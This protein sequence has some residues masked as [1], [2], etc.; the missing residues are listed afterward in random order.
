ML[1]H[2]FL[3]LIYIGLLLPFAAFAQNNTVATG[4]DLSLSACVQYALQH[5]PAL[6]QSY[7]DQSI[8]KSNIDISL[9]AWLPQAGVNANLQHYFDLPVA[10]SGATTPATV[11]KSGLN[12]ISTPQLNVSQTIFNPDVLYA[13]KSARSYS[14]Q[15][16]QNITNTKINLVVAVSK[17][18]YDLLLSQQQLGILEE[19]IARLEKNLKDAYSQY[20]GGT[21]DKVDYKRA[22]IALNNSKAELKATQEIL[23]V[24]YASLRQLIGYPEEQK[25]KVRFDTAQ[26]MQ[27]VFY[28]TAQTLRYDKR[29]EYQSLQTAMNLQQQTSKYYRTGFLPSLS[30]FYTYNLLYESNTFSDLFSQSYPNSLIGLNFSIPLFQGLKRVDN[31][32]KSK[33]QQERL[34]WDMANLKLQISTDYTL[35]LASYKSN[36]NELHTLQENVQI[37]REVYN[38]VKLQYNEGIKQYIE[39]IAAETD[40]RTSEIN[41]LNALFHLLESKL[42]LQKSL[43]DI[44]GNI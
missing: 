7:I 34:D 23:K 4:E 18:F 30:G 15:A 9:S 27:E 17:A 6:K 28:D 11:V 8:T 41:Y 14:L 25:L 16:K 32:H 44:S 10:F 24:K 3:W 42:D 5:Q 21:A 40:L 37:A 33:L 22:T 43:G 13:L 20:E 19:D 39:V 12:N 29:I 26:L 35:A 31:L 1:R 36:L 2:A 38:V